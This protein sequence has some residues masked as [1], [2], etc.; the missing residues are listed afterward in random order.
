[1]KLQIYIVII[2]LFLT[3]TGVYAQQEPY[4]TL[5]RYNKNVLNPANAGSEGHIQFTTNIRSQWSSVQGAPESQ[6]LSFDTN[7]GKNMG[8]GL[9]VVNDQTFIEKQTGIYIDFS[10]KLP[11]N[12]RINLFLGLKAGGNSYDVNTNGLLTFGATED[13]LLSNVNEFNPNIGIGGYLKHEDWFLSISVPRL[14][15]NDRID[16]ESGIVTTATERSHFYGMA[17]YNLKLSNNIEFRPSVLLRYVDTAPFSV[18][19]TGG[20]LF[21][22]K[23]ELGTAYRTDNAFSGFATIKIQKWLHFGYAYEGSLENEIANVS[24]GT[25]EILIRFAIGNKE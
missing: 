3:I 1:M 15:N 12:E 17:G 22:N 4:Y 5:Y 7:I 19:F 25:H 24:R 13:P 9:S 14:L 21:Y 18:D 2:L 8:L 6:S 23:F 20:F 11:L 10:Y 16:D